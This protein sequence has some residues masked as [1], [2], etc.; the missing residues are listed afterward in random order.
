MKAKSFIIS[1]ILVC[2]L[3]L[4]FVFPATGQDPKWPT[5][6]LL[7]VNPFPAGGV[8][9]LTN[10]TLAIELTKHLGVSMQVVVMPGATGGIAAD[11]VWQAPADGNVWLGFSDN[12]R[13]YPVTGYHHTTYKDWIV[14]LATAGP[15]CLY[16]PAESPFK[17]LDD[18][19]K[20]MRDNPGKIKI[21]SGGTGNGWQTA[22][23]IFIFHK[24]LSYTLVPFAGGYPAAVATVK[25]ESDAG[26]SGL[27]EV[28]EFLRGGKLRALAVFDK[29][30]RNV[31]GYGEIP[32]I[33]KWA[34]ETARFMPFGGYWGPAVKK[35]TPDH[36]VK[37]IDAAFRLSVNSET[38]QKMAQER[39][40]T[41]SP[42][43][44]EEVSKFME[45]ETSLVSWL[46]H[47]I[48]KVDKSPA[49]VGIPRLK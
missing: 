32:P 28:T 31:S 2:A 36:I 18:F 17:T 5:R 43:G 1:F 39:E 30:P 47:D 15:A 4:F 35:G 40:V 34:P 9:E 24:K 21:A 11:Y 37:R 44:P 6:P 45:T 23:E 38:M 33:T 13:H 42:M 3:N 8:S 12:F 20:A 25:Q 14:W 10:R 48:K 27:M 22:L 41:I 7:I 46:L 16:V 49:T 29:V 26:S 19:M